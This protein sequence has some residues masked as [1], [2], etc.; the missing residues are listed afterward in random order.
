M[1]NNETKSISD[2]QDN[3]HTYVIYKTAKNNPSSIAMG[4]SILPM[5]QP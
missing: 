1:Q 4:D 2:I 5:M 3:F